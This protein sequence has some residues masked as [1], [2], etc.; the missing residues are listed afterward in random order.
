[1]YKQPNF[2][3]DPSK[4]KVEKTKYYYLFTYT[5]TNGYKQPFVID[6]LFE[7]I[8]QG[9]QFVVDHLKSETNA[10][11]AANC[12]LPSNLIDANGDPEIT[13]NF[14]QART[15]L[16]NGTI[17]SSEELQINEAN[18]HIIKIDHKTLSDI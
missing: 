4:L 10:L 7:N 16:E 1:M 8:L 15:Y 9:K 11:Y 13:F 5:H 2:K 17:P 6:D 14:D 12:K 18:K 3:Y